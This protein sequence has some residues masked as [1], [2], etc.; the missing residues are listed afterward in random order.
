M[1]WII[2]CML[3]V[4]LV[5]AIADPAAA[6]DFTISTDRPGILYGTSIVPVGHWQLEAGLPTWQRSDSDGER[7]TLI[8]TPT[9]VRY[10]VAD[11][12]ELQIADSPYSRETIHTGFGGTTFTGASDVT[13]GAKLLLH[14]GAAHGPNIV[15]VGYATLPTGSDA[16][17]AGSPG[18]NL[19][20]VSGWSLTESTNIAAMVSF[21][22]I[23]IAGD[24]HADNGILA[25]N[26]A[27][28]FSDRLAAYLETGW[29]PGFSNA[30]D[31]ALVGAGLTWLVTNRFQL[32]S[33]FDRNLNNASPDWTAGVGASILF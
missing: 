16:F 25:M 5:C 28:S 26:L 10:G 2:L 8:T 6:A 15:L 3:S 14:S 33:F 1:N 11:N 22:R 29:F 9:Y 17:S 30:Q 13:F 7:D 19:N 20:L 31:Q 18:Y 24:R 27:H 12:L 23:P 32:D 21:S 4:V